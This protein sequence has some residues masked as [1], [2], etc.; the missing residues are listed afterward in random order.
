MQSLTAPLSNDQWVARCSKWLMALAGLAFLA[1]L[2]GA[3]VTLYGVGGMGLQRWL[4]AGYIVQVATLCLTGV[5][6]IGLAQFLSYLLGAQRKPGAVLL[7]TEKVLYL[8]AALRLL[9]GAFALLYLLYGAPAIA[10]TAHFGVRDALL[11]F[12]CTSFV[13]TLLGVFVLLALALI[14][15]RV[16]PII[17]EA[18]TLV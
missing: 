18:R 14:L 10:G 17:E 7:L 5:L 15:R 9:G 12:L 3:G 11:H 1:S 2:A 8:H 16:L 13:P 6:V 4:V